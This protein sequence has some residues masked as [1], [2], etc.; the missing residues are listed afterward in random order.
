MNKFILL[1]SLLM[2]VSSMVS[3][4]ISNEALT[5][6]SEPSVYLVFFD[7][8]PLATYSGGVD[9]LS[10]T[11]RR[12]SGARKLDV[13][14]PAS[15][16]YLEWLSEQQQ[17]RIELFSQM[18]NRTIKPIFVYQTAN[19]GI[20]VELTADEAARLRPVDGVR[21]VQEDVHYELATDRGPTFLGADS[22][23]DGTNT[24]ANLPN[25]GEGVIIGVIDTGMNMDHPL[26]SDTSE[27]GYD[28]AAANPFGAGNFVGWCDPGNPNYQPQFVCNN[29]YI[30]GWDFSDAVSGGQEADGPEDSNG[31]GSHTATTTAGNFTTAPPGGFINTATGSTFDAPS[32]SGVAPHAHI[33]SYDVCIV[34]CPGSAIIAAINQGVSDGADILSFSISGGTSPWNDND[35]T[36]L[37]AFAAGLVVV[38]AAGNTSDTIPNPVGQVNHR[39]PWL[40]SVANSTHDRINSNDVNATG[41][42]VPPSDT[43]DLFGLAGTG[44]AFAGDVAATVIYAGDIDANNFQGCTAWPLG[45]EFTGA[46]ALISRGACSF[47]DKVNNA[48]AAGAV[49]VVVFNNA[50]NL[51]IVMG[52]LAATT[53]PSVMVGL[54]DGNAL[55]S[56]IQD[57]GITPTQLLISGTAVYKLVASKGNV[58][59]GGS[60]RGPNPSFS[61]TKPDINAPGTNIFA[62]YADALGAPPQL[63]FLSGTSMATPHV[64]GAAALMIAAHPDWSPAEIMSAMM[65]TANS[66]TLKDDAATPSDPDDVGSGTVDLT[67][68]VLAGLAMDETF[69]N[70]LAANPA[71]GGDPS[72]LNLPSMRSNDCQGTCSWQRTLTNKLDFPVEWNFDA[73][74]PATLNVQVQPLSF[75]LAA[76]ESVTVDVCVNVVSTSADMQFARLFLTETLDSAPPSEMTI[77]VRANSAAGNPGASCLPQEPPLFADG[78]ED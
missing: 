33:I 2:A 49:S 43:T 26:I 57:N 77:A 22:V 5:N 42:G 76:G 69:D 41:P 3:A 60:L 18:L 21:S 17:A 14:A 30:G 70:H 47:A 25:Q 15:V 20:A 7:E 63:T 64:A 8:A 53:V 66:N 51:P 78:F 4:Q 28:Y 67:K 46:I 10:A 19:N 11:S 13:Q 1:G 71:T 52:G 23:W 24:P 29:K 27:D 45:V 16:A 59:A 9:G 61:V 44:P 62:G 75:T 39:S 38:A 40:L 55:V 74:A 48:V 54:D 68:A 72:T 36:F 12:A 65:L 34:S 56:F 73:T 37:D 6:G 50:S 31:H 58:L 35:R 32:M